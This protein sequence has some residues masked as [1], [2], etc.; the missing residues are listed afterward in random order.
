MSGLTATF[1]RAAAIALPRQ[2]IF[3]LSHMRAYTSLFGHILGS[4]PEICGYYEMHIG[5]HSWKS[6]VRQKLLYFRDDPVKPGAR[7]MFDKVLH[8]DHDTALGVLDMARCHV[9]FA[10]RE[11]RLVV[12]SIL[13]LY[14]RVDPGHEFNSEAFA[15]RYYIERVEE[16]ARLARG[17]RR[18]YFYMDAEALK[19]DAGRCL[20]QLGEWLELATPLS[21]HYELQSHSLRERDGDSSE[22]MQAGTITKDRSD[23]EDFVPDAQDMAHATDT[24]ERVR[25]QL[26]DGSQAR[27]LLGN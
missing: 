16:L 15:T 12:P 5:Y 11:P 20:P 7:Y 14:A 25:Q 1:R 26:I 8:N 4:N 13:K 6:L 27:S 10:L 2:H 18:P 24:F 22:R 23:Y 3:L 21:P 19:Q 17:M 9:I